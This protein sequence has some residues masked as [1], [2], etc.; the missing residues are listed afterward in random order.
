MKFAVLLSLVVIPIVSA[1]QEIGPVDLLE[2]RLAQIREEEHDIGIQI[3]AL[4]EFLAS[5]DTAVAE[6][7]TAISQL[8]EMRTKLAD[9]N[10]KNLIK[11]VLQLAFETYSTINTTTGVAKTAVQSTANFGISYAAGRIAFEQGGEQARK[12]MGLDASNYYSP[13][14][15][16]I[17]RL[18]EESFTQAAEIQKVYWAL[19]KDTA[20]YRALKQQETGEDPGER[21]AIFFKNN[22]VRERIGDAITALR[23]MI[24]RIHAEE[25]TAENDLEWLRGEAASL[26]SLRGG[27]AM[28]LQ[29]AL[30][31]RREEAIDEDVD[32]MV[33]EVD[34]PQSPA[35]FTF[36]SQ[37]EDETW[38]EYHRARYNAGKD[39]IKGILDPVVPTL[40]AFW[41][42][43]H[44]AKRTADDDLEGWREDFEQT[45]KL[46]KVKDELLAEDFGGLLHSLHDWRRADRLEQRL[47]TAERELQTIRDGLEPIANGFTSFNNL[48]RSLAGIQ[49]IAEASAYLGFYGKRDYVDETGASMGWAWTFRGIDEPTSFRP[50]YE[51]MTDFTEWFEAIGEAKEN[52]S[53][54]ALKYRRHYQGLQ[55]AIASVT[56]DERA[57]VESLEN[58]TFAMAF[59]LGAAEELAVDKP[60]C[61]RT[62]HLFFHGIHNHRFSIQELSSALEDAL[63]DHL[64]PEPAR[65]L[66]QDYLA[67]VPAYEKVDRAYRLAVGQAIS[68]RNRISGNPPMFLKEVRDTHE[69]AMNYDY[70]PPSLNVGAMERLREDWLREWRFVGQVFAHEKARSLPEARF[71]ETLDDTVPPEMEAPWI[72]HPLAQELPVFGLLLLKEEMDRRWEDLMAMEARD[73][74]VMWDTVYSL[75]GLIEDWKSAQT[76]G[77]LGGQLFDT[78]DK[79]ANNQ[80]YARRQV[81]EEAFAPP[82]I[83]GVA[84]SSAVKPGGSKQLWVNASS[85]DSMNFRWYRRSTFG[86]DDLVGKSSRLTVDAPDGLETYYCEVSNKN[87]TV[88]SGWIEVYPA[89]APRIAYHPQSVEVEPGEA[90][91][92]EASFY[93]TTPALVETTAAWYVSMGSEPDESYRKIS[94]SRSNLLQLEAVLEPRYYYY[95]MTNPWGTTR[96]ETAAVT[97]R[98]G[99]E[100]PVVLPPPADLVAYNGIFFSYPFSGARL[101]RYAWEPIEDTAGLSFS[102]ESGL[103]LGVPQAA[104]GNALRFRVRAEGKGRVSPWREMEIPVLPASQYPGEPIE[105]YFPPFQLENPDISGL[106]ADPDGDGR[107][108]LLE[109]AFGGNPSLRVEGEGKGL[110]RLRVEGGALALEFV[111]PSVPRGFHYVVEGTEDLVNWQVLSSLGDNPVRVENGRQRFR[112]EVPETKGSFQLLRVR[113][114]PLEP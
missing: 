51:R 78:A 58:A 7:E 61:H 8:E 33:G 97:I 49:G 48:K 84:E 113:V 32:A 45:V 12:A 23:E 24:N 94:D 5:A 108:N 11:V 111:R 100:A 60:Y 22:V 39:A 99:A 44:A 18:T 43:Y 83:E 20:Y 71:A 80:Q 68:A 112:Y 114:V 88:Q 28:Q 31:A 4:E 15:V 101:E 19:G 69:A 10:K 42:E 9:I 30:A 90:T 96:T 103:I 102:A 107:C 56:A 57:L 64:G 14:T 66:W 38:S 46:W 13:R 77:L 98:G 92:L 26:A 36:R 41:K 105:E 52:L 34:P 54:A 37:R 109:L 40:D 6:M 67:F 95:E 82:R 91:R 86:M 65:A 106:M 75:S 55:P 59:H 29:E 47:Q 16:S 35:T 53:A 79:M 87:G 72:H 21:G 73:E 70:P 74:N 63:A 76:D 3:T 81:W 25:G 2:D 104:P 17:R 93:M 27:V 110:P 50:F 62:D 85:K 89:A 1:A